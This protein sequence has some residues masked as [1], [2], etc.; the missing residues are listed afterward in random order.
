MQNPK[1]FRYQVGNHK[2]NG[3]AMKGM[4]AVICTR[5]GFDNLAHEDLGKFHEG[6]PNMIDERGHA[7]RFVNGVNGVRAERMATP[8]GTPGVKRYV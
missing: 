1:C 4:G 6:D 8:P 2:V 5:C 3:C 7:W